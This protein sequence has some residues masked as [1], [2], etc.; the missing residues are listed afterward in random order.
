MVYFGSHPVHAVPWVPMQASS[1]LS[2][3]LCTKNG[4]IS[5]PTGR[6]G[7]GEKY[8]KYSNFYRFTSITEA[9][10]GLHGFT[11]HLSCPMGPHQL[12]CKARPAAHLSFTFQPLQTCS[13][14]CVEV[15]IQ[16][17]V[18]WKHI[19]WM[20][21]TTAAPSTA[22]VFRSMHGG[23]TVTEERL[24]ASKM[25]WRPQKLSKT[26]Q[27]WVIFQALGCSRNDQ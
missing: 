9:P 6:P 3:S 23:P 2:T 16:D 14:H 21:W 18:F 12:T 26:C 17:F 25:D 13:E 15:Y 4:W 5:T 24:V 7:Y 1:H 10:N 8:D 19:S 22:R 27:N 11:P 20:K